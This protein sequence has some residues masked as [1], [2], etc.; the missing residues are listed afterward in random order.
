MFKFH[1]LKFIAFYCIK[2]EICN[3]A[4]LWWITVLQLNFASIDLGDICPSLPHHISLFLYFCCCIFQTRQ[5]WCE[6]TQWY[7]WFSPNFTCSLM[8]LGCFSKVRFHLPCLFSTKRQQYKMLQILACCKF[9][10]A[11]NMQQKK[12]FDD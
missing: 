11:A 10:A 2:V 8:Q 4:V 6:F 9:F 5:A 1:P 3:C 12:K 7:W